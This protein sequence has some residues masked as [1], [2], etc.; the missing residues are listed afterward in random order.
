MNARN[1]KLIE[2]YAAHPLRAEVELALITAERFGERSAAIAADK[3]LSP[4]GRKN[5]GAAELR[6]ALRSVREAGAP[7]DEMRAKLRAEFASITTAPIDKSDLAGA[8]AR[9]ELRA[10]IRTLPLGERAALLTGDKADPRFTDAVLEQP[11]QI[12]G[13]DQN[14]YDRVRDERL[15]ALHPQASFRAEKLSDEIAEA[16][17]GLEIARQDLQRDSGIK[18]HEFDA[19]R[20]EVDSRKNAPWL[21]RD[22]DVNGR[23]QVVVIRPGHSSAL[24]ATP[25]ERR[26][27]KYYT[28]HDEYLADRA[29]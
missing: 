21:K 14:F 4:E 11:A 3:N 8:L 12:S 9:Q 10:H 24:P 27:G 22:R 6:S 2:R 19:L 16:E 25:D 15:E 7:I 17:A 23:E 13:L 20:K 18:Q 5:K 1:E 28:S 29:A 26:D